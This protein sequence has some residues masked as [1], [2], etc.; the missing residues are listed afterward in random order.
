MN[1]TLF[2]MVLSGTFYSCCTAHDFC[3]ET[4]V[5][6]PIKGCRKWFYSWFKELWGFI[7]IILFVEWTAFNTRVLIRKN[8]KGH[9]YLWCCSYKGSSLRVT[10][11]QE[12]LHLVLPFCLPPPFVE[13]V[14]RRVSG[15]RLDPPWTRTRQSWSI[16]A[17]LNERKFPFY[18]ILRSRKK[19]NNLV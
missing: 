9:C 3:Q 18:T 15:H 12:V 19:I 8:V 10:T 5:N 13:C 11:S 7:S 16:N 4:E 1:T 14:A 6:E 17:K 2:L